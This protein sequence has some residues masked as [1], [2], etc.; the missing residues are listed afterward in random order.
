MISALCEGRLPKIYSL[1]VE[2]SV[3]GLHAA[4]SAMGLS[5]ARVQAALAAASSAGS[6]GRRQVLAVVRYSTCCAEEKKAEDSMGD[7]T[8][9][10]PCE[11]ETER[12]T[13]GDREV[14]SSPSM[15]QEGDVLIEV[16]GKLVTR[17]G[18]VETAVDELVAQRQQGAATAGDIL[19]NVDVTLLRDKREVHVRVPLRVAASQD[20]TRMVAFGGLVCQHHHLAVERRG[21]VPRGSKVYCSFYFYG[22]PA[23]KYG[24]RPRRWLIS[25]NGKPTP[26]LDALLKAA[27]GFD[28]GQPLRLM[29]MDMQGR[30]HAETLKLDIRYWPTT[31]L[32]QVAEAC[33]APGQ[34][35]AAGALKWEVRQC[36]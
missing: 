1:D 19:A 10:R 4:R 15:L 11:T 12:Q 35:G 30:T 3:L 28:E 31:E 34:R 27:S 22:S 29:M 21:F 9:K 14:S 20:T 32:R 16:C 7:V 2:L 25:V 5:D 8:A 33:A 17:F 36:S 6:D 26:Y 13:E 24:L 23:E 18:D